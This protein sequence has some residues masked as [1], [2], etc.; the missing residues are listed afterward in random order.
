M[1]R[2]WLPGP[3]P[4]GGTTKRAL[5]SI[6]CVPATSGVEVLMIIFCWTVPVA[7]V[8]NGG[9]VGPAAGMVFWILLWASCDEEE[10]GIF[11]PMPHWL[12]DAFCAMVGVG[13]VWAR[14]PCMVED[15]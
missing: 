1:M 14:L 7:E 2:T 3:K 12:F 8:D 11:S 13:D 9:F 15:E 6:I 5:L 10:K 4:W